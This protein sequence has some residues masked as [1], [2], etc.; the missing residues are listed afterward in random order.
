MFLSGGD[1][2]FL[3]RSAIS[4]AKVDDVFYFILA[5]CV[6]LLFVITFLMIYFLIRYNRRKHPV[7]APIDGNS[8]LEIAWT[9]APTILVLGIFYYG[10][11]GF[12]YLRAVPTGA[13]PIKVIARMWEWRFHYANGKESSTLVAPIGKP[14]VLLLNSR[15]VIHSFYVPAFRIKEDAVPGRENYLWFEAKKKGGYDVLCTQYCGLR[16]SDMIARILIVDEAEYETWLAS[17]K[18]SLPAGAMAGAFKTMADKGCLKCH[19]SDGTKLSGP[20][21]KGLF[22]NDRKLMTGSKERTVKADETYLRSAIVTPGE[23]LVAGYKD[24]MPKPGSDL[25]EQD[26]EIMI[27]YIRN[28]K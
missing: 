14:V 2:L 22:G 25:T 4:S 5:I 6:A 9:V 10:W 21:F 8:R 23:D 3:S 17:D 28:L 26:I 24:I 1:T 11:T 16:H 12:V 13:I 18:D 19:S 20:T 15:D 27:E 7:A